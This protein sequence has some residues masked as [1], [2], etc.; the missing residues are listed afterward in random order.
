MSDENKNNAESPNPGEVN[1]VY[2]NRR[3]VGRK[4][5]IG[6]VLWDAAQSFNINTYSGRFVTNVLQIDLGLQAIEQTI[7]GIWDVVNDIFMGAIIDKTRTRW[8][9]FRPYLLLLA[10]PGLILTAL[11]WLL[12]VLFAG[13]TSMDITKFVFYF[14]LAFIR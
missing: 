3:Y 11:Y 1:Y 13:R 5:T 6:F 9:K 14:I 10:V 12:P 2:Q 4:E 8:G 7:N